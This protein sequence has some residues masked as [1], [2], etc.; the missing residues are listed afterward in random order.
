MAYSTA[1]FP[2]LRPF[3]APLGS[4]KSATAAA[5]SL[6][7]LDNLFG[8]FF[9]GLLEPARRGLGSRVRCFG[10][11]DI[12]WAFLSQVLTR[13][14]SCRDALVRLHAHKVAQGHAPRGS[15]SA[16]CQARAGL[17]LPWL[18]A[19]FA[20]LSRWFEPRVKGEWLGRTVRLMD[21]TG[22]SMPDSPKNS[23]RWPYAGGQQ[24]GCGFPVGKLVGLFCLHSG[25]LVAFTHDIWKAHD[26]TLARPLLKW[27][28]AG[29]IL[30]A[31]RA[32]CSWFF[33]VLLRRQKVD[34]VIRLHHFRAVRLGQIGTRQE[35]WPRPQR[36]RTRQSQWFWQRLPKVLPVRLVRFAVHSRGFR[37]RHVIVATSLLDITAY[38]DAAIAKLYAQRWQVELHYRQIKTILALDNLRGLSPQ[39]IERELWLHAI[40]YNLVHALM[41][42]AAITYDVPVHQISFKGSLD[43]LRA[44]ADLMPRQTRLRAKARRALLLR[45]AHDLVPLRPNRHEPRAKK[46]RPKNYQFLTKPRKKMRVS[47]SRSL[48]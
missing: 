24:P 2:A 11:V 40:A 21:G 17:S 29:E 38:P 35:L 32:Y 36:Q 44:W 43:A 47:S 39:V 28:K 26:L 31:D 20:V 12:F 46:R 4:A 41:L 14:S 6:R 30:V 27:L 8:K 34:F 33:L 13:G 48:N 19:L 45:I 10:R 1:Y 23:A 18:R 22:F 9:L 7:G 5:A 42:E 16:Y 37:V 25:R 15:E 3:C